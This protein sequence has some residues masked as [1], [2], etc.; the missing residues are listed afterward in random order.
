MVGGMAGR[1]H[2]DE[3]LAVAELD[4]LAIGEHPVGRII[5]VERGVGARADRLQARAARSR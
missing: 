5:A 2:R 3:L 1:R 4:R